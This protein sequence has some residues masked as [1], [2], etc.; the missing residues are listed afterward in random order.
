MK[1]TIRN[2]LQKTNNE[3]LLVNNIMDYMYYKCYLCKK[4]IIEG[5][6]CPVLSDLYW[7]VVI[8]CEDCKYSKCCRQESVYRVNSNLRKN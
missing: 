1:K 2:V 5:R 8:V 7:S 4:Y 6:A 3:P